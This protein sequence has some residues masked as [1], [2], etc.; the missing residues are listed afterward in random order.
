MRL[1]RCA[2]VFFESRESVSVDIESLLVGGDG[3]TRKRRWLALAAHLDGEVEV[4]AVEREILG[5]VG[6]GEWIDDDRLEGYPKEAVKRLL[7]QGL[8][9][10]DDV[11]SAEYRQHDDTLRSGHWWPMAAVMHR[12]S[13]WQAVDSVVAMA[14]SEMTTAVEL[15]A[16]LGAPPPA[17]GERGDAPSRIPLPRLPANDLDGL[18]ARRA[19]C[20]N[21]DI[22]RSVPQPLLAR[23]LQRALMAHAQVRIQEDTIFLKKYVPSGG[24]LHP[25]EAYLIANR[26]E[27]LAPGL[28]HYHP[29][30]HALQPLPSPKQPLEVFSRAALAGQHWFSDA[31]VIIVL[32][33]R[34]Q[35][36]FWK[37]RLHA[38]AY[39]AG[40]LD[41]GHISQMLYLSATEAGLG[42]FVTSAVNEMEVEQAFALDPMQQGVV[43]IC[44][45]GWRAG[46]MEISEFDPA[47]EVWINDN[48]D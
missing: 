6:P 41:I 45:F 37:Y 35:R 15:R 43:A 30:D 29:I 10:G 38:K 24:G 14:D 3:L 4:S 42:A 8:L 23:M 21:F 1:R 44:G 25:V 26:V 39:R 47:N 27:G 32:A 19:T 11:E 7:R 33:L 13:R 46:K 12:H 9:I 31:P 28:Y 34:F 16:R 17:V 36:S 48:P 22:Q 5:E 18:L 20:R 2:I 40:V